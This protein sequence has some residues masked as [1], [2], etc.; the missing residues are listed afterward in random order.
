MRRRPDCGISEPLWEILPHRDESL[1]FL[2]EVRI[3]GALALDKLLARRRNHIDGSFVDGSN[4]RETLRCH[5]TPL[6]GGMISLFD[7]RNAPTP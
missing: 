6:R 7:Q 2:A 3:T 1:Y 5:K 4:S